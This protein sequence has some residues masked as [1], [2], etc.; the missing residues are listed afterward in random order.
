MSS[1]FFSFLK[2]GISCNILDVWGSVF[3]AIKYI[4]VLIFQRCFVNFN[5]GCTMMNTF[6]L[7]IHWN[8]SVDTIFPYWVVCQHCTTFCLS[9]SLNTRFVRVVK[10]GGVFYE[11]LQERLQLDL[12]RLRL[13]LLWKYPF[14]SFFNN[15]LVLVSWIEYERNEDR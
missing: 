8:I 3:Y 13:K 5:V 12:K 2:K 10:E 6:D 7:S 15:V 4:N 1:I 11:V 14:R 9:G